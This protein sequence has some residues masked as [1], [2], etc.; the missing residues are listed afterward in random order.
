V[1]KT[2]RV[3]HLLSS[4]CLAVFKHPDFVT[5]VDFHPRDDW[6]FITGCFDKQLRLWDAAE[7]HCLKRV[8]APSIITCVKFNIEGDKVFFLRSSPP[9]H[10]DYLSCSPKVTIFFACYEY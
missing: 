3:W 4:H 6:L 10:S 7:G 5:S 9:D 8:Q 1:D 2:A